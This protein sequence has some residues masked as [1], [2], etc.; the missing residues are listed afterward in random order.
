MASKPVM[1]YGAQGNTLTQWNLG[2]IEVEDT[3]SSSQVPLTVHL[4]VR[5]VVEIE[6]YGTRWAPSSGSVLRGENIGFSH[7]QAVSGS[8]V[9][10][11]SA[12]STPL[13]ALLPARSAPLGNDTVG[14]SDVT[15]P[16][17][18]LSSDEE[19][20]E[21][22][23]DQPA[24]SGHKEPSSSV[25]RKG[26]LPRLRRVTRL[27]VARDV[28]PFSG[29]ALVSGNRVTRRNDPR[30]KRGSL[31]SVHKG[32]RAKLDALG[33]SSSAATPD[34]VARSKLAE[35]DRGNTSTDRGR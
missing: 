2:I 16:I 11:G 19:G 24:T 21:V 27:K 28:L 30:R 34:C 32:K 23:L 18:L 9:G 26:A 31:S 22:R 4:A 12:P 10:G 29:E 1:L 14:G 6:L 20:D 8:W 15:N 5:N 7:V 3:T 17:S 13:N 33:G 35:E 25:S